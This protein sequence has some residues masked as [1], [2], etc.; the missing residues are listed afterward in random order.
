MGSKTSKGENKTSNSDEIVLNNKTGDV[1]IRGRN[2]YG[3]TIVKTTCTEY[4]VDG[5]KKSKSVV[6]ISSEYDSRENRYVDDFGGTMRASSMPYT[7]HGETKANITNV[8]DI[9]SFKNAGIRMEP[10]TGEEEQDNDHLLST[11]DQ[12]NAL[13]RYERKYAGMKHI[14][15]HVPESD[16]CI[17]KEKV[18]GGNAY[19]PAEKVERKSE[20][21]TSILDDFPQCHEEHATI[22]QYIQSRPAYEYDKL[23][24]VF[25][26][27]DVSNNSIESVEEVHD[28][29]KNCGSLDTCID[30]NY[31]EESADTYSNTSS[32]DSSLNVRH[33]LIS[34]NDKLEV[35]R[36]NST[37]STGSMIVTQTGIS[38]LPCPFI[39]ILS[40]DIPT[41]PT[42]GNWPCW[43]DMT[44][45]E[46][47]Q[48]ETPNLRNND[49]GKPHQSTCITDVK[50]GNCETTHTN[51]SRE[52]L[53]VSLASDHGYHSIMS[54]RSEI[55]AKAN[56]DSSI[57]KQKLKNFVSECCIDFAKYIANTTTINANP[58]LNSYFDRARNDG[59]LSEQEQMTYEWLRYITFNTYTGSGC[60][61][62]LARSGF[63]HT[64]Q[65]ETRCFCCNR[66]YSAWNATEDVD[67]THRRLSPNCPFISGGITSAGNVPVDE[68]VEE[69]QGEEGLAGSSDMQTISLR[70]SERHGQ[71][72]RRRI[73]SVPNPVQR[74]REGHLVPNGGEMIV[75]ASDRG[76]A[77]LMYTDRERN[78]A[79]P[80]RNRPGDG[81]PNPAL[82]TTLVS[83]LVRGTAT[84]FEH[85]SSVYANR[86][87]GGIREEGNIDNLYKSSMESY[88]ERD[89]M[90][91]HITGA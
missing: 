26:E 63:Y 83:N 55:N 67:L 70:N 39:I 41:D 36:L 31:G 14:C 46:S 50:D 13:R 49:P 59:A 71:I 87:N 69:S 88:K 8:E 38:L 91:R 16:A 29:V 84:A 61:I 37:G 34:M 90:V 5:T 64:G 89:N 54:N 51:A 23:D 15:A 73:T 77:M 60:S 35:I 11:A 21:E 33:R 56:D 75:R 12:R 30:S 65:N 7:D 44:G 80:S 4:R 2:G 68:C 82:D 18:Q 47:S 76:C 10:A 19:P 24:K 78:D 58:A 9:P 81:S 27:Y 42:E 53:E 22:L 45:P 66:T 57:H 52:E 17:L 25:P 43:S 40:K 62:L 32:I 6:E 72:P 1:N 86:G 74:T 20:N 85:R 79:S 28:A 3:C 48:F